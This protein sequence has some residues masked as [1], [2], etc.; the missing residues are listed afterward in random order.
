LSESLS[1]DEEFFSEEEEEEE[2]M[3]ETGVDHYESLVSV[4]QMLSLFF[5][6]VNTL[7]KR[8]QKN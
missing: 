8:D 7:I 3:M 5:Y 1:S 6:S 2:V 4:L